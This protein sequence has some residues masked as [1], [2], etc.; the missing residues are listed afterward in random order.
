MI[1]E[2]LLVLFVATPISFLLLRKYK[3]DKIAFAWIFPWTILLF[4]DKTGSELY[5]SLVLF[6]IGLVPG[7]ITDIG[8]VYAHK[9][10]Y[11]HY[12]N[13]KYSLSVFWGWG[14][15]TLLIFRFYDFLMTNFEI[16]G[17]A[18]F[19]V[20][21]ILWIFIDYTKGKT[22]LKNYWTLARL[23]V[24]ILFLALSNDILFLLVAATG[25]VF[26]ELLGTRLKIWIYYDFTPSYIFL[27]AGYAQL[28]YMCLIL[29]KF[30]VYNTV[31]TFIQI[32]LIGLL[33]ILFFAEYYFD[34]RAYLGKEKKTQTN[35]AI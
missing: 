15:M 19:V 23:F 7:I 25:A 14:I 22:S 33:I 24:S 6:S 12:N 31:P 3:Q 34:I 9:W 16:Y 2:D 27:G 1:L 18:I 21:F 10:W 32:I 28:S 29:A 30:I 26:I 35:E 20:L 5:F 8:G 4:I 17:W 11:P 13:R